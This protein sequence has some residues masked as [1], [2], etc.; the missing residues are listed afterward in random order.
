[1]GKTDVS[2]RKNHS[3]YEKSDLA[4]TLTCIYLSFDD[5]DVKGLFLEEERKRACCDKNKRSHIFSLRIEKKIK[6]FSNNYT[7]ASI[8]IFAHHS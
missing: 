7:V 2:N 3:V 6:D 8:A 5:S 4:L 1:M